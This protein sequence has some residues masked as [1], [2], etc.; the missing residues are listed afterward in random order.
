MNKNKKFLYA[1]PISSSASASGVFDQ[2]GAEIYSLLFII[3]PVLTIA[4]IFN[5]LFL[6]LKILNKKILIFQVIL[7][8]VSTGIYLLFLSTGVFYSL[9]GVILNI[10]AIVII[11]LMIY[12]THKQSSLLKAY[13][14][15]FNM[16]SGADVPPPVN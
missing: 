4:L 3:L 11:L 12:L 15:K 2:Q 14:K 16:D 13:N 8:S 7:A 1:L 9:F 5:I 10:L 6:V